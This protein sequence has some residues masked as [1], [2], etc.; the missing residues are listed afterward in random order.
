MRLLISFAPKTVLAGPVVNPN[1]VM[2][3]LDQASFDILAS[4]EFLK[5]KFSDFH[6]QTTTSG[7]DHWTAVYLTAEKTHIEFM[8]PNPNFPEGTVGLALSVEE[9][10]G[11]I[12][13]IESRLRAEWGSTLAREQRALPWKAAI[14]PWFDYVILRLGGGNFRTWV[15]EFDSKYLEQT[16]PNRPQDWGITRESYNRPAYLP[17]RLLKNVTGV[18]LRLD[19]ILLAQ[20]KKTLLALEYKKTA[21]RNSVVLSRPDL[22][23]TLDPGESGK[24]EISEIEMELNQVYTDQAQIDSTEEIKLVFDRKLPRAFLW[25][26]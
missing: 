20:E 2:W 3:I 10:V 4:N 9:K 25:R 6:K 22:N 14:I 1:H 21:S 26:H 13:A 24:F 23:V 15:M 17:S 16:R 19:P 12:N 5:A 11:D 18:R 8:S 7:A